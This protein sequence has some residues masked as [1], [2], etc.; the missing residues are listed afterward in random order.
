MG[1]SRSTY[2]GKPSLHADDAAVLQRRG[3][4]GLALRIAICAA[5]L[6]YNFDRVPPDYLLSLVTLRREVSVG[7]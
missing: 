7:L 1:L 6:V 4:S 2:Y 5:R 3:G